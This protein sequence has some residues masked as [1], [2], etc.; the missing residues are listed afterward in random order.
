MRQLS[1]ALWLLLGFATVTQAQSVQYHS[2][3]DSAT[4]STA[5][6]V[7]KDLPLLHTDQIWSTDIDTLWN[8]IE[9]I[10][11]RSHSE[12]N[13][14]VK[15]NLYASDAGKLASLQQ[16]VAS[17]FEKGHVPAL[18]SVVTPLPDG[19]SYALDVV[20]VSKTEVNRVE[21]L[22]QDHTQISLMP[23]GKRI[24]ISGQ[25]ARDED[26]KTAS[27]KTLEGLLK[28]VEFLNRS[29]QDVV[30]LKAFLTP[31]QKKQYV[32]QAVTEVFG[33]G[34]E[35]PLVLVDWKS[36][37]TLPVEIEMIVW[38][39]QSD[40]TQPVLEYLTPPELTSSPVFSRVCRVNSGATCYLSGVSAPHANSESEV[41]QTFGLLQ[42]VLERVDSD[43]HHLVKATYYVTKG[44]VSASLGAVRKKVYNPERPPSASKATVET[45]SKSHPRFLMDM[46]AV[47]VKKQ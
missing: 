46:I 6:T 30:A 21:L 34:E 45:I 35:P 16:S 40:K 41:K 22:E 23:A 29:Q 13:Q 11:K 7:V 47:P 38:G 17:R 20:A 3:K 32:Q 43:M 8:R 26:L 1:T 44:D 28:T 24:Y 12:L 4:V 33:R 14:V 36:S 31:M 2:L 39:G 9:A 42:Q 15:C 5:A 25:A 10:L 19:C 37:D 18:C 27:V